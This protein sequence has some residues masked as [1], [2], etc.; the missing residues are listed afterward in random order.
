MK[1]TVEKL[2]PIVFGWEG[3]VANDKLDKGGLTKMGVTLSTWKGLGYDKNGDGVIDAKDLLLI[4]KED[5]INILRKFWKRW[6]A[7]QIFN[8]AVANILVDWVW[9]SGS[10]GIE[11]TQRMLGLEQDGFVG[12]VTLAAVNAQAP[13]T[14]FFQIK[15]ERLDF[16]QRICDRDK[17]QLRFLKGWQNRINSFTYYI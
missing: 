1:P 12:P 7:D 10:Y 4:N 9:C 13:K 16:V 3:G 15:K 6:K 2:A 14:F 11:I 8:P 5:A 17:T